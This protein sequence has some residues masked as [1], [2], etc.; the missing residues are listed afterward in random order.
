MWG[1]GGMRVLN[2]C[3]IPS[4]NTPF[5]FGHVL[6]KCFTIENTVNAVNTV[7]ASTPTPRHTWRGQMR[8]KTYTYTH[9]CACTRTI[10]S[11]VRGPRSAPQTAHTM[12]NVVMIPSMP[13]VRVQV[14]VWIGHGRVSV[15]C[16]VGIRSQF[17]GLTSI[18]FSES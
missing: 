3:T 1:G 14:W 2:I 10:E 4:H 7:Q 5:G 13:Y 9:V 16:A 8:Q 15:T 6:T 18:Y 17:V 12:A 11:T